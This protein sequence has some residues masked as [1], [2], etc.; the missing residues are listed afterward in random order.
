MAGNT[1]V[2][3]LVLRK[4][5]VQRTPPWS[6]AARRRFG[7]SRPGATMIRLILLSMSPPSW[8]EIEAAPGRRGPK[9]RRA[10]AL[11]GAASSAPDAASRGIAILI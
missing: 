3:D 9:R 2:V 6:A 4:S 8:A 7:R 10:G 5:T 11:Q 1:H